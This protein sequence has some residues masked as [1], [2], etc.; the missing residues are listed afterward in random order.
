M[1]ELG[2]QYTMNIILT[3]W[4]QK[5]ADLIGKAR[6]DE[7]EKSKVNRRGLKADYTT[8]LDLDIEG[9]AGEIAAARA[10]N[11][12]WHA[13]VNVGKEAPDVGTNI[14]VR[15]TKHLNG[16]LIIT[17]SDPDDQIY[18]LVTGTRPNYKIVGW[19]RGCDGKKEQ[20]VRA[21]NNRPPAYFVPQ[22][23]LKKV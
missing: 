18:V 4:E 13:S 23:A 15:A 1:I 9:A 6:R 11:R 21:P 2:S 5:L 20:Y 17:N 8:L 19:I 7:S 14:Q 16:S 22:T 12:Y 3:E 10:L